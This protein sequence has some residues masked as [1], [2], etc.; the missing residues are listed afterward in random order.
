MFAFQSGPMSCPHISQQLTERSPEQENTDYTARYEFL[1]SAWILMIR[2]KFCWQDVIETGRGNSA[3]YSRTSCTSFT[4]NHNLSYIFILT[5]VFTQA[6]QIFFFAKPF[7]S[8]VGKTHGTRLSA[9]LQLHPHSRLNTWIDWIGKRQLQDE[10][11][12]IQ[13]WGFCAY[14]IR[15]FTVISAIVSG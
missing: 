12:K 15:E 4:W 9:L 11:R 14:Y 8:L 13:I 6:S 2:N 3:I 10:T 7:C 5:S 1:I